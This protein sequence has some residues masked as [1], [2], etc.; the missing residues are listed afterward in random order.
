[1]DTLAGNF[2]IENNNL[3]SCEHAD[4]LYDPSAFDLYEVMRVIDGVVIFLEDHL[5]R[6]RAGALILGY[7]PE[8][9]ETELEEVL[10]YLIRKN[11][12]RLGNIKLLCTSQGSEFQY[13][14]YYIPH[15]YP[16][17]EDYNQGVQ[18]MLH[19]VSRPDPNLKQV[20]VSDSIREKL[21]PVLDSK[22]IYE[23]LL[24]NQD[25]LI[26][27]GSK[28]NFFLIHDGK[29]YTAPDQLV[30]KGITRHYVLESAKDC[31]VE[32]L[33]RKITLDE[34]AA[35]EAAFI[36]GT[37]PKILPVRRIEQLN[38]DPRNSTLRELMQRYN[39]KIE[40]YIGSKKISTAF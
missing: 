13:A 17:A 9:L 11:E 14:C 33:F 21:Y 38:Y 7:C 26:T 18:V 28:S 4:F 2:F 24:I 31:G 15:K 27:E 10:L 30:L 25:N 22:G 34:L 3:K 23:A 8:N 29:L 35:Y 16:D 19:A 32:C 37:S 20:S 36:C 5:S 40:A 1:M 6:L 12:N 39:Q